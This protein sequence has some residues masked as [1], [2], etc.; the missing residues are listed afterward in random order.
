MM[1][2]HVMK[3]KMVPASDL[4]AAIRHILVAIN[5]KIFHQEGNLS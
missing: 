4:A 5:Q 2:G 3:T 1:D